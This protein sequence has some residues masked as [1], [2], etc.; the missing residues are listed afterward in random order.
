MCG[1]FGYAGEGPVDLEQ[2]HRVAALAET[3][4]P[5]AIGFAYLK[6]EAGGVV[7]GNWSA[8]EP[9]SK[10]AGE[11][12]RC[13]GATA[14]LGHCRLA[15][16]GPE[17]L[18]Q[19][20]LCSD[21]T[22]AGVGWI[23]HNGNL[24]KHAELA[25]EHGLKPRTECDSEVLGLLILKL[26]LEAAAELA[27]ESPCAFGWL[28]GR[29]IDIRALGQPLYSDKAGY[30]CSREFPGAQAIAGRFVAQA[31][32]PRAPVPHEE[33]ARQPISH[34]R[35]VPHKSIAPNDY[36]PNVQAPPEH[37]LLKVSLLEDG[38]TQPIVVFVDENGSRTIIDGEHRWRVSADPEVAELT[39]GLVPV[40][41]LEGDR[42]HRMMS[43]I[44]HNRARGE[45]GV[46]PMAQIV[47]QLLEEGE[48]PN[49]IAFL[50]Q[51]EPEEIERL[52]ERAGMPAKVTREKG[53]G[54][55]SGW[56]P[57]HKK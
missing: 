50:L 4:G 24:Y 2:L 3:R 29:G 23:A 46:L 7:M 30:F 36:N 44:R 47:R 35:W 31:P 40:V 16:F 6:P 22:A 33:L 25:A 34:V 13:E 15:T 17:G 27:K 38:W 1:L 48:E 54:F 14:V 37:R 57:K 5:H 52:A 9:F 28:T 12:A 51:M 21:G 45:H 32:P 26:G 53:A 49:E 18:T 43:T 8:P 41:F 42:H 10:H 20:I 11:L 39:G 55:S 56:I 19:P